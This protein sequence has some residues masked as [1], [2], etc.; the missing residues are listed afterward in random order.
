M[1]NSVLT[2]ASALDGGGWSMPRPSHLSPGNDP[3]PNTLEA[4]WARRPVWTSGEN[5]APTGIRSPDFPVRIELLYRLRY[6]GPGEKN[7][8][9]LIISSVGNCQ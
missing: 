8:N 3:V 2:L 1:Y 5:L 6:P 7:H 4:G 9:T